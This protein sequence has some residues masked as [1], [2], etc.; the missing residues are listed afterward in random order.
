[1]SEEQT[2][3]PGPKESFSD[4][5]ETLRRIATEYM[6]RE[7]DPQTLQATELLH[8]AF[9][10]LSRSG[11]TPWSDETH[12]RAIVA[13]VMRQVLVDRARARKTAKRGHLKLTLGVVD[14]AVEPELTLDLIAL[15]T[16]IEKVAA[17][18]SRVARM[19][20][21]RFFGGFRVVEL[22]REFGISERDARREWE[23][24]RAVLREQLQNPE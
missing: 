4:H 18:D 11:G 21:L 20:E 8:E 12:F 13:R 5:Y 6:R 7:G 14:G 16:A 10:R 3:Q 19:I 17:I 24:A 2:Q 1:M 22:A 9:L 15:D 23:W